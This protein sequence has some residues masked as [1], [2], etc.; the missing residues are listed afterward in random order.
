M[1]LT[2][3]LGF[4]GGIVKPQAI[5][6]INEENKTFLEESGGILIL[7]ILMLVSLVII[8]KQ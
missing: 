3:I 5:D 7:A 6:P 4:L 2:N 1:V 8:V